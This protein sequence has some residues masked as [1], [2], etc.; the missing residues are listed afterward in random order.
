VTRYRAQWT[1][2]LPK[3]VAI[4]ESQPD[5]GDLTVHPDEERV[6]GQFGPMRRAHFA[7]GRR[8][9]R[10]AM[11]ELGAPLTA[12]LA[13]DRRPL[14]PRGWVGSISHTQD[15]AAAAVAP[16]SLAVSL[17]IDVE[18]RRP[19][20]DPVAERITSKDEL[21]QLRGVDE[22]AALTVL[23]SAKEAFYKLQHPISDCFLG[24]RDVRVD[25]E[26]GHEL[27]LTLLKDAGGFA[28]G[29]VFR[30]RYHVADDHVLTAFV[31]ERT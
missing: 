11:V 12:I 19:I 3:G 21:A 16:E 29:R 25:I 14:W 13:D 26:G 28:C 27:A 5:P 6:V 10:A 8:C 4:G 9:A 18:R 30:A 24:F 20:S 23:F 31:L 2:L 15:Y 17:G 7:A 1:E 22:A